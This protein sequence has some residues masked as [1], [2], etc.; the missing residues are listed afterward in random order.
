LQKPPYDGRLLIITPFEIKVK[1]A[2][3]ETARI[4]NELIVQLADSVTVGYVKPGGE[5]EKVVSGTEKP[6]VYLHGVTS[7]LIL[8]FV[9]SL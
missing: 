2:T 6:T 1:R 3:E 9:L 4:R 7:N 8:L 5:L